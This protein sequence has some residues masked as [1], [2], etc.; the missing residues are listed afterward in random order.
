VAYIK[1]IREGNALEFPRTPAT[2]SAERIEPQREMGET[3]MMGLRLV[4]EGVSPAG[5]ANRFGE[6]LDAV[7][8]KQIAQLERR[9]LLESA[10][11][12]LRL[13]RAGRLLG[14]Q[15]FMEFV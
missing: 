12:A 13:T 5:F 7:Y 2:A 14:N 11:D 10:A 3:M 6:T 15:V 8:G 1:R 4:D 9:G